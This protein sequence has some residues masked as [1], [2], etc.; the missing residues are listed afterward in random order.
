M[1]AR[2]RRSRRATAGRQPMNN[3]LVIGVQR[4]LGRREPAQL[5]DFRREVALRANA[6]PQEYRGHNDAVHPM[7]AA[8]QFELDN[9]DVHGDLPRHRRGGTPA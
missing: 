8:H 4:R 2:P 7:H 1:G 9:F 5:P 6:R 3:S